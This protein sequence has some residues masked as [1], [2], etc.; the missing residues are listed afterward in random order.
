MRVRR[1]A[2]RKN[3]PAFR[4][5]K[6]LIGTNMSRRPASDHPMTLS[7]SAVARTSPFACCTFRRSMR[8]GRSAP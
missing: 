7:A 6:R 3:D 1:R 4:A 8:L 2:E 5:K